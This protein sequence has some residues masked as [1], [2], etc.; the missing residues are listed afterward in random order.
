MLQGN[1]NLKPDEQSFFKKWLEKLQ[2]DSW[3]L[4]LVISGFALYGIVSAKSA[5]VDF[6]FWLDDAPREFGGLLVVVVIVGWRIFFI[7]LLVH[8][9]LRSLWIGAIGLRYISK[10]ID[11]V[12]LGYNAKFTRLLKRSIGE[13]DDFIHKLENICSVIFS[14]T[15]LLFLFF[16][17][18]SLFIAVLFPFTF[19]LDRFGEVFE[20]YFIFVTFVYVLLALLVFVD[21]VT[22]GGIR[23]I[24]EKW[25][26][27]LYAPIFRFYSYITLSFLYRPL[28]Y[29]FLDSKYTRRLFYFSFPYIFLIAINGEL[30]SGNTKPHFISTLESKSK[31]YT[32]DDLWYEDRTAQLINTRGMDE[33]RRLSR[34]SIPVILSN[35][36]IAN[37]YAQ[38]FIPLGKSDYELINNVFGVSPKYKDG[39][40]FGLA[41]SLATDK[42]K[43]A[44]IT[45]EV[46]SLML[47]YRQYELHRD[48]LEEKDMTEGEISD[49]KRLAMLVE[50][51]ERVVEHRN[52][53]LKE[54]DEKRDSLI[55]A[56]AQSIFEVS[57]NGI[58]YQDSLRC[59]FN[60]RELNDA[61]GINCV[62]PTGSIEKGPQYLLLER[63]FYEQKEINGQ[64][65]DTFYVDKVKVPFIRQ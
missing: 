47:L 53:K 11:Y 33:V 60:K 21:F 59:F 28:L 15:F 32:I 34:T 9:I 36:E 55:L 13:Y 57:I 27:K 30:I 16:V 51:A 17:S 42:N 45:E 35:F 50:Q 1:D 37:D 22:G 14:Y 26:S 25:V 18:F 64:E 54:Y 3:Q 44:V 6:S 5:I 52:T 62:F 63:K 23:K 24:E 43:K 48:G 31:G 65:V 49:D 12:E 58:S 20:P 46:D 19:L 29:N 2:Q 41:S 8:V 61:K 7:N 40:R 38:L 4:E 39:W 10:E 56:A